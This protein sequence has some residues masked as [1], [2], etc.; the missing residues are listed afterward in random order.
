[1]ALLGVL[2]LIA[3]I[4]LSIGQPLSSIAQSSPFNTVTVDYTEL[5]YHTNNLVPISCN[6]DD[7]LVNIGHHLYDTCYYVWNSYP[8]DTGTWNIEIE[9]W[10]WSAD[11]NPECA[12]FTFD[13]TIYALC[14]AQSTNAVAFSGMTATTTA[15]NPPIELLVALAMFCLAGSALMGKLKAQWLGR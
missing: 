7:I 9:R 13:I 5:N 12:K 4:V 10:P 6:D 2:L 15:K 1:M 14:Y 3:A 8:V 11:I